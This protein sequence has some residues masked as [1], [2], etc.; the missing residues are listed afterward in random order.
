MQY[1][2]IISSIYGAGGLKNTFPT[3]LYSLEA[4]TQLCG[5]D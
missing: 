5:L 2:S 1:L 3:Q 4:T